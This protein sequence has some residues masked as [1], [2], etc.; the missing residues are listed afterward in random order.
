MKERK[1]T[2]RNV[3]PRQRWSLVVT[4]AIYLANKRVAC[5][6]CGAISCQQLQLLRMTHYRC[7]E[8][9]TATRVVARRHLGYILPTSGSLVFTGAKYILPTTT[10]ASFEGPMA[11]RVARRH[12][13]YILPT[14]GSLVV[15]GAMISC[16]QLPLLQGTHGNEGS[17]V[18]TGVIS[19][20]QVG[21]SSS[22]GLYLATHGQ[23]APCLCPLV[24]V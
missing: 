21:R 12:R 3:Q 5:R 9:P 7:F 6:H 2:K 4:G 23:T 22:L 15:T 14:S 11:M 8:G 17:L 24:G 16:Q 19:C 20:Q 10:A 1:G 13:G 18:V